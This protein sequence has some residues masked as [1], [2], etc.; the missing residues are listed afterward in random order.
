MTV[1]P[2]GNQRL[3]V[4][5]A[6]GT[7]IA[8]GT[9]GPVTIELPFG[10]DPNRTVTVQ[11]RN[12]KAVLSIEVVLTPDNG[13]ATT[14]KAEINNLSAN[15]ASVKVPVTFPLNTPVAVNAWIR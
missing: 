10:S 6:A 3:D 13:S 5:E 2:P 8:E 1:F 9:A 15:P 7:N 12:F 14:V 11:A 4:I